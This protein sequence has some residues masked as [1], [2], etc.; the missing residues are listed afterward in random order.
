MPYCE[1]REEQT[2]AEHYLIYCPRYNQEREDLKRQLEIA[3]ISLDIQ[4]ILSPS[5]RETYEKI[6]QIIG[7]YMHVF[8]SGRFQELESPDTRSC[9]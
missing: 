1:C 2:T 4:S 5:K 3:N 6:A 9:A 8:K 7:E